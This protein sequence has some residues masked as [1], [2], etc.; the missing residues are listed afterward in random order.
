MHEPGCRMDW[1][2]HHHV[3]AER[4]TYYFAMGFRDFKNQAQHLIQGLLNISNLCPLYSHMSDS[5]LPEENKGV[6]K[7]ACPVLP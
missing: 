7:N 2:D 4:P 1:W 6:F 3:C 5:D